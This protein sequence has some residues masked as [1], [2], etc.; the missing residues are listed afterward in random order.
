MHTECGIF[1]SQL[2]GSLKAVKS[3]VYAQFVGAAKEGV[4]GIE[5]V[6]SEYA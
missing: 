2:I 5:G 6:P 1:H 4:V 3:R